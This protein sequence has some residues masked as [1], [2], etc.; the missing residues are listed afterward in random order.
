[1]ATNNG[2]SVKK[3]TIPVAG[4]TCFVTVEY[5]VAEPPPETEEITYATNE[6]TADR[7]RDTMNHNGTVDVTDDGT[8]PP[9]AITSVTYHA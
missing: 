7:L 3:V 2:G 4:G 1:M 8:G 6:D 5:P 9:A